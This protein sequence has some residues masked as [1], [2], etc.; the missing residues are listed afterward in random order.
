MHSVL[1]LQSGSACLNEDGETNLNF[2]PSNGCGNSDW[3][4][5][6]V[7]SSNGDLV[8]IIAQ[9]S[10]P[11]MNFYNALI[12]QEGT[13]TISDGAESIEFIVYP[14]P[15]FTSTVSSEYY[16]CEDSVNIQFEILPVDSFMNFSWIGSATE[17]ENVINGQFG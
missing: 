10:P 5:W 13:Y 3:S 7:I 6:S 2:I 9:G 15:I 11:F 12:N 1:S 17:S 4:Q 14:K 8:G 16:L